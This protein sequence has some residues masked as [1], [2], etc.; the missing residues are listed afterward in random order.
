M[1][2]L[3]ENFPTA[4][5]ID[6]VEY[7]LNCDFKTC[8]RIILAF[9][10]EALADVEKQCVLLNNLYRDL[11]ANVP[12]A[13]ELGL[14]FLNGGEQ[15]AEEYGYSPRVYSFDKDAKLIFAAFRQTHNID[16]ENENMHWWKFLALFMDLGSETSFC[17]LI[18]LRRRLK[19]GKATKEE[20]AMAREM[21]SLI[22]LPDYDVRTL[23]EKLQERE[24]IRSLGVK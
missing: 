21:S 15:S 7:E 24:F 10:D 20:K 1:N 16:L 19:T 17:N 11:P 13:L 4:V 2:L 3:I 18:S 22:D 6:G 14:K 5:E 12:L 8:I 23:E 9:E